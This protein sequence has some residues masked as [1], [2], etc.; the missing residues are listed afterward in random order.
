VNGGILYEIIICA[1]VL[2]YLEKKDFSTKIFNEQTSYSR[3]VARVI[4]RFWS[5]SGEKIATWWI[6]L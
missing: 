6:P 4:T 1:V 5:N 3:L 2:V